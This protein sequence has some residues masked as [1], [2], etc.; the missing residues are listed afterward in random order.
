[1][2]IVVAHSIN[3][4][5]D[6]IQQG[7]ATP[8]YADMQVLLKAKVNLPGP[9]DSVHCILRMLA[10]YRTFLPAAHPLVV[11]LQQHYGFMN[12]YDPGWVMYSTYVPQF[13]WLKWLS[14]K[15]T[16]YFGQI[17]CNLVMSTR[18]THTGSLI[19]FKSRNSGSRT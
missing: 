8:S 1:M 2:D 16:R 19:T 6:F 4:Q 14:L 13:R 15:L 5:I 3:R 10:V 11:F 17:D 7:E 9:D 12:A 18:P